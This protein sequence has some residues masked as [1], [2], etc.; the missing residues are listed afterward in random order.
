MEESYRQGPSLL[1]SLWRYRYVVVAV[2]LLAG[3][4]GYLLASQQIPIYEASATLLLSDPARTPGLDDSRPINPEEFVP[5]QASRATARGVFQ[6]AQEAL[7]TPPSLQEMME[8]VTVQQSPEDLSLTITASSP[9][10][11]QAAAMANALATSFMANNE[12]DQR[13]GANRAVFELE[14]QAADLETR[15]AELE[16]QFGADPANF[17]VQSQIQNLSLRLIDL[18]GLISSVRSNAELRGDGVD[19]FEQAQIPTG[20]ASPKPL[21]QAIL[22]AFTGGV[23]ASLWAYWQAGRSQRV[24]SRTDPERVLGVPLLG[25]VPVF[26]SGGNKHAPVVLEPDP[27]AVA[28]YEFVLSSVQ[29]ALDDVGG[30]S[31]MITSVLPADGKTTTA[32][33][34]VIAASRDRRRVVLV[35]AD[36]RAHGLTRALGAQDR[37]GLSD[38]VA[39]DAQLPDVMRKYRLND[40]A[41]IPVVTAGLRRGDPAAMLRTQA[42]RRTMA[43]IRKAAELVVIDTSPLLA[44]ADATIVAPTADGMVIVVNHQTPFSELEKVRERLNFVSTPLLGYI[45][46]RSDATT[47]PAYGYQYGASAVARKRRPFLTKAFWQRRNGDGSELDPASPDLDG[48]G[49]SS[50]VDVLASPGRGGDDAA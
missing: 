47:A 27:A 6:S 25:E 48:E 2:P 18:Q 12:E 14:Q 41:Q 10:P 1:E 5:Q 40:D 45:Y 17:A 9:D 7:D 29:F 11:D 19:V 35:D 28:A 44:V 16:Q 33:Q 13:E 32:L 23:V 22:F 39:S 24:L 30:K 15:L 49:D 36:I 31:V 26:K 4:L 3:I 46:N 50:A 8:N 42:F 34:L 21:I 37:T 43:G 20:P 38:L